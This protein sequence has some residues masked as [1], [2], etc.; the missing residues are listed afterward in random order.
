MVIPV[1][2][3]SVFAATGGPV[4]GAAAPVTFKGSIS[5]SLTGTVTFKPE[6]TLKVPG[7][8]ITA[9]FKGKNTHC[10][11]VTYHGIKT[12]LTQGGETLTGSTENFTF[13]IAASTKST[14]AGLNGAAPP[15]TGAVVDWTG[16]SPITPTKLTF[17]KGTINAAGLI[18]YTVGTSTGSFPGT[19]KIQLQAST[20]SESPPYTSGWVGGIHPYSPANAAIACKGPGI[21]DI[22][23]VQPKPSTTFPLNDNEE[24]GAA[25]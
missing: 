2:A 8:A 21:S 15:I 1:T 25:F 17:K 6:L 14:C 4:S 9:T 10:T 12:S 5:C 24:I 16:T 18:T 11:G 7:P 13:K 3:V 23:F 20:I 19:A 22:T